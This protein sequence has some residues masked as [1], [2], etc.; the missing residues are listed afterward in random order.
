MKTKI[1]AI[2]LII[3]YLVITLV[4]WTIIN[5]LNIDMSNLSLNNRITYLLII[6]LLLIFTVFISNYYDLISQFRDFKKNIKKYMREY[7]PYWF[8]MLGLMILSNIIIYSITKL[9]ASNQEELLKIFKISKEY[10]IFSTV[11]YAPFIEEMI[12][13]KS[14]FDITKNKWLFIAISGLSFGLMHCLNSESLIEY[15]YIIPYAIPGF[16]FAYILT[17]SKNIFNTISIHFFHNLIML[18]LQ[19]VALKYLV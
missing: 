17:K 13:R 7:F 16:F 4:P 5:I 14:I 11:I 3:L 1:K 6:Q 18:I 10:I 12:F 15:L 8:K 19:I 2:S 9:R